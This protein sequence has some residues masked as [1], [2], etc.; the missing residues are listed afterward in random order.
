[1]AWGCR[2]VATVA[3]RDKKEADRRQGE[4]EERVLGCGHLSL[5]NLFVAFLAGWTLELFNYVVHN[6]IRRK[7]KEGRYRK[8]VKGGDSCLLS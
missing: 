8:I 1:M 5:G 6:I 4:Y 2:W 3:L 7:M